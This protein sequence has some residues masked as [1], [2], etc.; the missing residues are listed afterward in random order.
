MVLWWLKRQDG[1]STRQ[2]ATVRHTADF[3]RLLCFVL[4]GRDSGVR[5]RGSCFMGQ[6]EHRTQVGSQ[7]LFHLEALIV[8]LLNGYA[9]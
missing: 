1:D 9:H 4:P 3:V 7:P 6:Q 5:R 8:T 2:H